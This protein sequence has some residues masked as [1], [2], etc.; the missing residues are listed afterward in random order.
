[1]LIAIVAFDDLAM[2][3]L[4]KINVGVGFN[5]PPMSFAVNGKQY[6][7]IASGLYRNAK[8]K[9]SRSPELKN[10]AN[11]TMLFVFGL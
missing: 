10:L 3:E 7:A 1:M 9:L 4:W 5:A 8:G 6:I 11:Q 2:D